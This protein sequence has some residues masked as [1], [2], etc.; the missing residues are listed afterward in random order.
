M[1]YPYRNATRKLRTENKHLKKV[2][3]FFRGNYYVL[4]R[5]LSMLPGGEAQKDACYMNALKTIQKLRAE[6]K[7][8]KNRN[9]NLEKQIENLNIKLERANHV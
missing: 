7:R 4:S 9:E 2:L 8:L 5:R 1:R 3:H 6:N